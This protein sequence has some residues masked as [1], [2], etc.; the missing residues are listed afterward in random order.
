[1]RPLAR[2]IGLFLALAV[3]SGVASADPVAAP[4]YQVSSARLEGARFAGLARD[5]GDLLVTDVAHGRLLHWT[6]SRGFAPFGPVLPHGPDVIGDPTGPYAVLP[7][8]DTYLVLQG[9]QP[10]DGSPSPYDHALL[11]VDKAGAVDVLHDDFW[12]P[13]RMARAGGSLYVIDSARNSLEKRSADGH[14]T[15]VF[16]FPRLSRPESALAAL[17][18][19]EFA[20]DT[21]YT[22]DAVPTGLALRDE[23]IYVS[24]FGGFPFLEGAGRVVRLADTGNERTLEV[25]HE[26]LN[27][28]V[29][30]A[31]DEEGRLLVL[32]HGTYDPGT[33]FVAGSGRLLR[34][35]SGRDPPTVLL[36]RLSRPTSV[37]VR[38]PGRMA[39][40]DLT[41]AL[42]LLTRDDTGRPAE[43]DGKR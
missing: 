27:A 18:P 32:E 8:G 43:E 33:G 25:V 10:V 12:N 36:D 5:G 30:L 31:F 14:W 7:Q 4:G 42:V 16:A 28:P 22:F 6:E 29:D 34:F 11:A 24:L 2:L 26:T 15:R 35:D 38:G 23:M 1:M 39:V 37:L 13:F 3:S 20:G 9:W 19:T 17:S 41:G 40:A 21:P